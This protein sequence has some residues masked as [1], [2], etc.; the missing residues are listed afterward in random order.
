[1]NTQK[2]TLDLNKV[3][4]II[5]NDPY[6]LLNSFNLEYYTDVDNVFMCCPCHEGSDNPN[7]VSISLE[8][9][10]WKCWTRG[11]QQEY[12][13]D[14]F[15]FIRGVM[16]QI[17]GEEPTFSQ[18]LKYV[19]KIY[20]VNSASKEKKNGTNDRGNDFLDDSDDFSALVSRI[21][22]NTAR[23]R[24]NKTEVPVETP[25]CSTAV[26]EY[27]RSR[28][29]SVDVLRAFGVYDSAAL[30][31]SI[32]PIRSNGKLVGYTGR[33]MHEWV[34]PKFLFNEGFVKTRYLYNYDTALSSATFGTMILVEGQG[35]VWRLWEAGY[36]NAVG[37]FGKD[38]SEDQK[39]LLLTGNITKLIV[40]LDNDQA[41]REAKIDIQRKLGR[42]FT[43]EFPKTTGS[44]IG[45]KT[46]QQIKDILK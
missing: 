3:K 16:T 15:G 13:A 12:N 40:L 35:D 7:A 46:I 31:R 42:L 19:C 21:N 38:I 2:Q 34:K 17:T 1:M 8:K 37:L 10:I 41:G 22:R 36:K 26:S 4:D 28:G 23:R 6:K 20:D 24:A 5:F 27:F 30:K 29:F 45:K 18:I 32:I 44:D 43:L 39:S 9:K 25:P 14:I 11:C 33:A